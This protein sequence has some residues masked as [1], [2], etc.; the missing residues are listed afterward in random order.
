MPRGSVWEFLGPEPIEESSNDSDPSPAP[1][2]GLRAS[3]DA[4]P[5]RARRSERCGAIPGCDAAGMA[6]APPRTRSARQARRPHA[7]RYR[8]HSRR[9]RI[10]RQQALL[11]GMMTISVRNSAPRVLLR[12]A[13]QA[14]GKLWAGVV[15]L[16]ERLPRAP[17]RD[18]DD[19]PRF[20]IF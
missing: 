2:T 16:P 10:P 14:L 1:L 4:P 5:H 20:P 17:E 11:E 12:R 8:P 7:E 13:T 3:R 9:R 18:I 6:S 15:S 19:Y